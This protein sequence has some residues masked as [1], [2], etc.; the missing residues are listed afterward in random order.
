MQFFHKTYVMSI[1][2]KDASKLQQTYR[3]RSYARLK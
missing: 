1:T 2:V 3:M